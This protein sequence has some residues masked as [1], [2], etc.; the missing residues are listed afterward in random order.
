MP[1]Q[2][3]GL[4][5][6]DVERQLSLH[7]GPDFE[8]QYLQSTF[9]HSPV[10][11]GVTIPPP[12]VPQ[13]SAMDDFPQ[14]NT[15][16]EHEGDS[17]FLGSGLQAA[18]P[19]EFEMS[20]VME[21]MSPPNFMGDFGSNV[22][23]GSTL[24]PA[25]SQASSSIR[26]GSEPVKPRP[27]IAS[28]LHQTQRFSSPSIPSPPISPNKALDR[29]AMLTSLDS[30]P[31]F[32]CNPLNKSSKTP[33]KTQRMYVEGLVHTL[34]NRSSFDL[35]QWTS[36]T[37]NMDL[38]VEKEYW[39]EVAPMSST[40]RE[41]WVAV[42]QWFLTKALQIHRTVKSREN[43]PEGV[44]TTGIDI[45][46]LPPDEVINSYLRSYILRAEPYC[47]IHPNAST[48]DFLLLHEER[49]TASLLLLL[50]VAQGAL[51]VSTSEARC[52]ASGLTEACRISLFDMIEKDI[53]RAHDPLL[54][55]SALLFV[56]LAVWSGDKWHMD[57]SHRP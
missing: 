10:N 7:G 36:Q 17:A 35:T 16:F 1:M 55:Q 14:L 53:Y 22:F 46:R 25:S 34:S 43:S 32:R 21:L 13:F 2:P 6:Q 49:S 30:W 31:F 24:T 52:L 5:M 11:T 26:H 54:L 40:S 48:P 3:H 33:P 18:T 51:T 28:P 12:V 19:G 42:V 27:D 56:L 39:V 47:S 29:E 8:T 20:S 50:M 41:T 57:V 38:L 15:H 4:L 9:P 23:G 44:S 45:L 37:A